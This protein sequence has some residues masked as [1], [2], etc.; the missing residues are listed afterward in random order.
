MS[1]KIDIPT[2]YCQ[3][4]I[5]QQPRDASDG[6]WE[7]WAIIKAAPCNVPPRSSP[8]MGPDLIDWI[9]LFVVMVAS[10]M[11]VDG[12]C[13]MRG[14][15]GYTGI[16]GYFLSEAKQSQL[17]VII[18]WGVNI[19]YSCWQH[20]TGMRM[21][22]TIQN[23]TYLNVAI[24]DKMRVISHLLKW[25]P[26]ALSCIFY[27]YTLSSIKYTTMNTEWT[28]G[29]KTVNCVL[30]ELFPAAVANWFAWHTPAPVTKT[31]PHH[32]HQLRA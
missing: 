12:E 3:S 18:R 8:V 31:H 27:H 32:H 28:L 6:C 20:H 19:E 10:V 25:V 24:N 30:M 23:N 15:G 9:C 16:S 26:F 22:D 17:F 2:L 1:R 4:H 21:E 5:Q 29:N 7:W 11:P 14:G 13:I